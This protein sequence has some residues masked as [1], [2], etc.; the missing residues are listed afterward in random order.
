MSGGKQK[1]STTSNTVQTPNVPGFISGPYQSYASGVDAL[2]NMNPMAFSTPASALQ[3]QAFGNAGAGTGNPTQAGYNATQ[4]LM[5]NGGVSVG[6]LSNT[7]FSPYMNPYQRNVI[8][9]TIGDWQH[10]N[11]LALN[12]LRASAPS[13][14]FG[15]DRMGVAEGQLLGDNSRTLATTLAG[16][17]Q[18]NFGNAQQLALQDIGNRY[19]A[20]TFNQNFGLNAAN[21]LANLGMLGANNTRADTALQASL[22]DTQ[23]SIAA[24]TNPAVQQARLLQARGGLLGMIPGGL[25]T[26]QTANSKGTQV[27]SY[28]PGLLDY[29]GGLANLGSVFGGFKLPWG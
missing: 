14:A 12:S 13:G 27:S 7:D 21:Q 26:G 2:G 8:D 29:V 19:N 4:G 25:F 24:D 18:S 20:A 17:N 3:T 5:N 11:D 15:G 22:G 28:S 6:Q 16:L 10:A 9:T 1:V 23:R